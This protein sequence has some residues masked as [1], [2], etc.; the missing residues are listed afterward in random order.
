MR[1]RERKQKRK[2]QILYTIAIVFLLLAIFTPLYH[3]LYDSLEKPFVSAYT[4]TETLKQDAKNIFHTWFSKKKIIEENAELER[5]IAI[6][7]IDNLRTEYLE[8]LLE[9]SKLLENID[10]KIIHGF[11]LKKNNE[12]VITINIGKD[13]NI[14]K[15]DFVLSY[16]GALMG[17][18]AEVFD[19]SAF[20]HL[21]I[22]NGMETPA[23]LFPQDI[24]IT[25]IGNGNAMTTELNRDVEV[26]IGDIVYAQ[27]NPGYIIGSVSAIDFDPRDP[28]K[29]VYIAPIHSITS[30]QEI[31]IKTQKTSE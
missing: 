12:G 4:N 27:E 16:D 22:K 8:S 19:R 23:I 26:S 24:S 25:L 13:K 29:K 21:F 11:V 31:G 20:V 6:L 15:E 17:K 7:K 1:T 28:V 9:K 2:R 30:L 3:I 14:S 10:D 18:V 5:Q